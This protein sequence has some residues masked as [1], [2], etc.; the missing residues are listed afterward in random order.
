[1][2]TQ[3]SIMNSIKSLFLFGENVQGAVYGNIVGLAVIGAWFADEESGSL[4]T[5]LSMMATLFVF[6]SAHIYSHF[7]GHSLAKDKKEME[8][9]VQ[10]MKHDWPIVQ[11]GFLPALAL[12]IGEIGIIPERISILVS[13]AVGIAT[14]SYLCFSMARRS[15]RAILKSLALATFMLGLG[16]F[17][18]LL[19][20]RLG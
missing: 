15:G 17:V 16:L 2:K 4:E 9:I 13:I 8:D 18:T 20:I 10:A 14:L 19:E 7:V 5:L 3:M 1:M 12:I 11:A 6:W